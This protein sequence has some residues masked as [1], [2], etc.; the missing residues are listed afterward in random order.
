MLVLLNGGPQYFLMVVSW[1]VPLADA[2]VTEW[3]WRAT[4]WA[5]LRVVPLADACV[6]EWRANNHPR[7]CANVHVPLAD[8]CVTEWQLVSTG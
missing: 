2:C 4:R 5:R 7:V 3:R 6:T 1:H 8:A